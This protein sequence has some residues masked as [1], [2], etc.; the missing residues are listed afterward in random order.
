[1]GYTLAEIQGQHHRMFV[2]PAYAQSAEYA[3]F[4]RRLGQRRVRP[5]EYKR[6]GK[7]GREVWIQASYNPVF[8]RAGK[9]FKVVKIAADVTAQKMAA[10]RCAQPARGHQPRAGGDRVQPR[11]H[12]HH[13]QPELSA[14]AMGYGLDE[15]KG[16]HH[17]MFVDPTYARAAEY[18]QFWDKLAPRREHGGRV[19]AASAR[20]ARKSGSRRPTTRSSISTASPTR[21]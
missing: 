18:Q 16:H 15:I 10:R 4:W 3:E 14:R 12:D 1:M 19:Q 20:A 5:A 11:R 7:G 17:R 9:P 13:R 6:L 21:S 2:E 8:D